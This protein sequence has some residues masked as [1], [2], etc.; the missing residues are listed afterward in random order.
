MHDLVKTGY[1]P[2]N[3][4]SLGAGRLA[5]ETQP[6]VILSSRVLFTKPQGLLRYWKLCIENYK[7]GKDLGD[8]FPSKNGHD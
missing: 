1:G 6:A 8:Q 4:A 5:R 3:E 2:G 7:A